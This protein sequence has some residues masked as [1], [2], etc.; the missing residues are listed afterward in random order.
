MKNKHKGLTV[1][2]MW[3]VRGLSVLQHELLRSQTPPSSDNSIQVDIRASKNES[4]FDG[5]SARRK[6]PYAK[7]TCSLSCKHE[8]AFANLQQSFHGDDHGTINQ[9]SS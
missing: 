5:N 1:F 8:L 3:P 9:S 7:P 2:F 6:R 4:G